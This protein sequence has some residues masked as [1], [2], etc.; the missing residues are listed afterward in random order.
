MKHV[1]NYA[2]YPTQGINASRANFAQYVKGHIN[3]LIAA[4]Q[5]A[6]GTI[7][8]ETTA[9]YEDM[10]GAVSAHEQFF[11]KRVSLTQNV[12]AIK[13]EF[14]TKID[15]LEEVF[16]FKFHKNSPVYN[17][18]FP[19]GVT[20]Y[21]NAALSETVIKMELAEQLAAKYKTT[22]GE[23]YLTALQHVRERF[24]AETSAQGVAK[25]EVKNIIPDYKAKRLAADKQLLKN[26][27][28]IIIHNIDN[29]AVVESF[30]DEHLIFPKNKKKEESDEPYSLIVAPNTHIAANINFSVGDT[31]LLTNTGT[32]SLFYY[33]ASA[34]DAAIPASLS[35]LLPDEEAEVT[36]A[37]LGAPANK[38][39][40]FRPPI[41][42]LENQALSPMCS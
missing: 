38:Y 41:P 9:L 14:N 8:D 11:N 12:Q 34:A 39:L 21:K 16:V 20:P 1:L 37:E 36:A 28:T 24:V 30:F 23:S 25:G 33:G 13:K 32:V 4:N 29:P 22:I 10:F 5:P 40:I 15:E 19:H 35:E 6:Y 18:V 7:T 17:E 31:L 2:A 3:Y 42:I 26:I 27:C